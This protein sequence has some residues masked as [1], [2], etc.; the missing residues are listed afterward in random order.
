MRSSGAQGLE[1][2]V[3]CCY[4]CDAMQRQKGSHMQSQA[5]KGKAES[6]HAAELGLDGLKT[7]PRLRQGTGVSVQGS[8]LPAASA[9]GPELKYR[10]DAARSGRSP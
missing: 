6:S 3:Q 9:A 7:E 5:F 2:S 8:C 4:A 10:Q 1:V